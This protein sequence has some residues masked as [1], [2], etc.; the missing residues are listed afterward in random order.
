MENLLQCL[1][2]SYLW[3]LLDSVEMV[4]Q[5]PACSLAPVSRAPGNVINTVTVTTSILIIQ[6]PNTDQG[7]KTLAGSVCSFPII[8][9]PRFLWTDA[10][11]AKSL[12]KV[13]MQI[14]AP[15]SH[16]KVSAERSPAVSSLSPGPAHPAS[17]QTP[18]IRFLPPSV[19]SSGCLYITLKPSG[20]CNKPKGRCEEVGCCCA[21][22]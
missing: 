10:H 5:L 14:L 17:L 9:W 20:H 21:E 6:T 13:L 16:C 7:V 15:Q 19:E 18:H 11:L 4:S 3:F 1:S 22:P 2:S 8:R 12:E